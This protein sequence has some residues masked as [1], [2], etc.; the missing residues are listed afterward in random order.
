MKT[1]LKKS[2]D[3]YANVVY[4]LRIG[5]EGFPYIGTFYKTITTNPDLTNR[6]EQTLLRNLENV[7]AVWF[8]NGFDKIFPNEPVFAGGFFRDLILGQWPN[9][10]DLFINTYGMDETEAEDNIA[11]F[12]YMLGGTM[13]EHEVD[14]A[15]YENGFPDPNGKEP[16]QFNKQNFVIFNRLHFDE[17][18]PG[19]FHIMLQV[20]GRDFGRNLSSP[21]DTAAD[22]DY[23]LVMAVMDLDGNIH[24][25]KEFVFGATEKKVIVTRPSG[26]HRSK[27]RL[28]YT[29]M[30]WI[31]LTKPPSA[32]DIAAAKLAERE[33]HMAKVKP[34]T[35]FERPAVDRQGIV[36]GEF[37]LQHAGPAREIY[38]HQ[39]QGGG[40]Q[41]VN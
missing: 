5:C 3:K 12:T 37:R 20:I 16:S 25:T 28:G 7:R 24:L 41:W 15:R 1:D 6:Y 18:Q 14:A 19:G 21:L 17:E 35:T 26:M 4:N 33:K 2:L 23:N 22:F 38:I 27:A 30:E 11:L 13:E 40:G 34:I 32:K 36:P 9:D 39:F 10:L 31:D 29:G 8:D